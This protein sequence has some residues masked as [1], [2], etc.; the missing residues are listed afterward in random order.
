MQ[1][2]FQ[3]KPTAWWAWCHITIKRLWCGRKYVRT[4]TN[5]YSSLF[6]A[7]EFCEKILSWIHIKFNWCSSLNLLTIQTIYNTQ[8][9]LKIFSQRMMNFTGKGSFYM[10]KILSVVKLT[11]KI[12]A[13]LSRKILMPLH[14]QR[15]T[16][17]WD[18]SPVASSVH[19]PSKIIKEPP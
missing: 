13:S 3:S 15:L 11:S 9:G 8:I 12:I 7:I 1:N 19:L 2:G 18:F 16:V 17:W 14:Q 4:T 5:M 10:K 6:T